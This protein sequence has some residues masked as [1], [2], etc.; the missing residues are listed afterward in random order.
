MRILQVITSLSIGGAEKLV[1]DFAIGLRERGH[2]VEVVAFDSKHTSIMQLLI[3]QGIK[4]HSF[5]LGGSVYNP[6]NIWRVARVMRQGWD[7]VH[8]HNTA[9]QLFCAIASLCAKAKLVTTEHSSS[10]RR[11]AFKPLALVDM[12]MYSRY[13]KIICISQRAEESLRQYTNIKSDKIITINNGIDYH[14]F[15]TASPLP[16]LKSEGITAVT[17]VAGFRWE[18]D[19][20][21]LIRALKL[22]PQNFH[23]YLV[24]IGVTEPDVR[25]LAQNEGV[26]ERVHFMGVRDDIP[27][28]LAASDYVVMSSHFEGLSLSSLEGM[29]CGKPFFASNVNG[30]REV[31]Q[32]AGVLFEHENADELADKILWLHQNERERNEVVQACMSRAKAFD[33]TAT[34]DEYERVYL[35][36]TN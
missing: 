16:D 6:K 25:Q 32:G 34:I 3:D 9:P 14:R 28:I 10:N 7:I 35:S 26:A 31:V 17:M 21:T 33:I 19:Q 13:S 11:R 5:H 18:K 2:H 24:G 4:V 8:S 15:S 22:L 29:A 20:A 12:M 23:V 1:A 30:L 36:L 27:Q